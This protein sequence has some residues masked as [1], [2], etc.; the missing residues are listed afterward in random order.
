MVLK[1]PISKLQRVKQQKEE[2]SLDLKVFVAPRQW[3]GASRE[4]DDGPP[5]HSLGEPRIRQWGLTVESCSPETLT[6]R[7]DR[8]VQKPLKIRCVDPDDM[9]IDGAIVEPDKVDM[10]VPADWGI[11]RQAVVELTAEGRPG[12]GRLG[13]EEALPPGRGPTEEADREV[14]IR[15]PPDPD[16]LKTYTITNVRAGILITET[17]QAKYQVKVENSPGPLQHFRDPRHGTGQ[18]GL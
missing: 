9:T 10:Y 2:G 5:G 18:T 16:R 3:E 4:T 1:G 8:L 6:V 13:Q 7:I 15:M 12:Q 11:E 17:L 14:T